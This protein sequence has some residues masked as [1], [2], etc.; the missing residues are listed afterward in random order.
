MAVKEIVA[1]KKTK[2]PS[3]RKILFVVLAWPREL[4]LVS[5]NAKSTAKIQSS[6]NAATAAR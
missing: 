4:V 1:S 3:R 5:A 6:S 2:V